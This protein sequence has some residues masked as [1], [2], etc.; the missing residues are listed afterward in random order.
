MKT[1][2]DPK[3]EYFL[4]QI[5]NMRVIR[6]QNGEIA[7]AFSTCR[8]VINTNPNLFPSLKK[9]GRYYQIKGE[10]LIRYE[11]QFK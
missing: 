4:R 9:I 11:K 6:N 8:E 1:E 2:I 3:K 7:E 5:F 10:D